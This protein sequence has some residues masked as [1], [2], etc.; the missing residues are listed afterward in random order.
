MD[1]EVFKWFL[2]FLEAAAVSQQASRFDTAFL[3]I[4]SQI[5]LTAVGQKQVAFQGF[6]FTRLFNYP[7]SHH[8]HSLI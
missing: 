7:L 8:L 5:Y 2:Y 3:Y 4:E 6:C 1:P